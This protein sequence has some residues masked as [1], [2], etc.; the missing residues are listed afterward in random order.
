MHE[1][2]NSAEFLKILC[3]Q[4]ETTCV[5]RWKENSLLLSGES[6]SLQL[7]ST[8]IEKMGDS[9]ECRL[10]ERTKLDPPDE[11]EEVTRKKLTAHSRT[12][13]KLSNVQK[14]R[15]C[16]NAVLKLIAGA[17]EQEA[18]DILSAKASNRT[19]GKDSNSLS[20]PP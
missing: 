16:H 7:I 3:L 8:H 2:G 4:L 20:G 19:S 10:F 18:H 12:P 14:W 6:V 5:F 9:V 13:S 11:I 15:A 1:G 17:S